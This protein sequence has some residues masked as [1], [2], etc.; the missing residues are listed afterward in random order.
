[1]VKIERYKL[2]KKAKKVGKREFAI[3]IVK[4]KVNS[5]KA[6][7]HL[8]FRYRQGFILSKFIV[9]GKFSNMVKEL[10]ISKSPENV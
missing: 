1:M 8:P 7:H 4:E 3:A 10:A 9:T 6:K 2:N 5:S